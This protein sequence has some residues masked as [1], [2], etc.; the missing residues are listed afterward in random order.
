MRSM[1]L[2]LAAILVIPAISGCVLH[3][4]GHGHVRG[5]AHYSHYDG[6]SYHHH[7][8]AR[9]VA[10]ARG[11]RCYG[12]CSHYYHR[13]YWYLGSRHHVHGSACGHTYREG[14]WVLVVSGR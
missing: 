11:H 1:T 3:A 9:R 12:R 4:R 5:H 7:R 10:V 14:R 6:P 8:H 2:V 13:G